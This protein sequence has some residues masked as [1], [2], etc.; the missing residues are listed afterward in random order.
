MSAVTV[1]SL[2]AIKR[3]C[4]AV[5]RPLVRG[6][7]WGKFCSRYLAINSEIGALDVSRLSSVLCCVRLCSCA[8]CVCL[9]SLHSLV[10]VVFACV[11][12]VIVFSSCVTCLT[13]CLPKFALDACAQ[14]DNR[15]VHRDPGPRRGHCPRRVSGLPCR[16]KENNLRLLHC[17]K[18]VHP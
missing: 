10:F 4:C 16:D 18:Q 11:R 8:R 6:V 12:C 5:F 2:Q 1:L 13:E 7:V 17:E 14:H 9:C 15:K 3:E